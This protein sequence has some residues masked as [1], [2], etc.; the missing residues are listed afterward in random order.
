MIATKEKSQ[1]KQGES[2][3]WAQVIKTSLGRERNANPEAQRSQPAPTPHRKHPR[4]KESEDDY[5]SSLNVFDQP[6]EEEEEE[7]DEDIE[8]LWEESLANDEEGK[9]FRH[10]PIDHDDF[11]ERAPKVRKKKPLKSKLQGAQTKRMKMLEDGLLGL[12]SQ[13][14]QLAH[15]LNRQGPVSQQPQAIPPFLP[16]MRGSIPWPLG[17]T[18]PDRVHPKAPGDGNCLWHSIAAALDNSEGRPVGAQ[19]GEGL[20]KE[21]LDHLC[22]HSSQWAAVWQCQEEGVLSAAQ[23]WQTQWADARACL[24]LSKL[25][26]LTVVIF[27]HKDQLIETICA[28]QTPPYQGKVAILDYSGDHYDPLPSI[29]PSDL[30]KIA[31][32]TILNPWRDD[33]QARRWGGYT[34]NLSRPEPSDPTS[35]IAKRMR[36]TKKSPPPMPDLW[37]TTVFP[38]KWETCISLLGMWEAYVR[39][40]SD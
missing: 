2:E 14:Q 28:G 24:T 18:L 27:N 32:A 7:E 5:W 13:I 36:V 26:D 34:W 10:A 11:V 23:D 8:E 31:Q 39:A 12:Q 33:R 37:M 16:A 1:P 22:A 35:G 3:T 21:T 29:G 38:R 4:P 9:D 15:V 19:W 40:W 30:Q 17:L 20:K 25:K 6:W